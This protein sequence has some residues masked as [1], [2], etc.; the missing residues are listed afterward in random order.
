MLP[1]SKNPASHF[2]KPN[3]PGQ[4]RPDPAPDHDDH[5]DGG[6]PEAARRV[7]GSDLNQM[8]AFWVTGFSSAAPATPPP[9]RAVLVPL[10]SRR[11]GCCISWLLPRS[12]S[13]HSTRPPDAF[14]HRTALS[15][16]DT[17]RE[18]VGTQRTR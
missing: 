5:A 11:V 7:E 9:S 13:L 15:L 1:L 16:R 8:A 2:L 17:L 4:A 14:S 12:S 10:G 18:L 6:V 3:H